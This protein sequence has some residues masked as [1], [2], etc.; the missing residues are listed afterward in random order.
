VFT[1][2]A[3][4]FPV[5]VRQ[6]TDLSDCSVLPGHLWHYF[7]RGDGARDGIDQDIADGDQPVTAQ[8]IRSEI[9]SGRYKCTAMAM[10]QPSQIDIPTPSPKHEQF[11][12]VRKR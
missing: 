3:V 2:A 10:A 12:I 1:G 7:D 8:P 6:G 11:G 4:S 5:E 9:I